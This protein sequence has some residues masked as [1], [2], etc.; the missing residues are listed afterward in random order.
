VLTP[1]AVPELEIDPTTPV[2]FSIGPSKDLYQELNEQIIEFTQDTDRLVLPNLTRPRLFDI[3]QVKPHPASLIA[4]ALRHENYYYGALWISYDQP[5]TFSEDEVRF[6]TT[7]GGQAAI[8]AANS[9]LYQNA[10][11]GRRRLEAILSSSPDPMLVTDR[12]NRL[13]LANPAA[14]QVLNLGMDTDEGQPIEEVI[15]HSKIIELMTSSNENQTAE[16]AFEDGF[17]YSATA[18]SVLSEGQRVGRVCILQDVTHFKELDTLKSE[19][20]STVSHDLRT[21]LTLMRGYAT[22]LEMVGKLNEQ[23][24]TYVNKIVEGVGSMSHLVNNLLDLGRIE[25]GIGLKLELISPKD[26]VDRV[27]ESLRLQIIQKRIK[28]ETEFALDSIQMIEADQALLQQALHNLLDNAIKFTRP[29]G[30]IIVRLKPTRD[31]MIFEVEDN[32]IGISPM[33]QNFLFEKFHRITLQGTEERKGT[34]LG[35]AIVKSI[36]ERHNGRVWVDSKLGQG[37]KFYME[38]PVNQEK[39]EEE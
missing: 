1:K 17:V 13:L 19:F 31:M 12:R 39:H 38:I 32:G 25:A 26:V 35:L 23:Q 2:T 5:H 29:E 6:T 4:V 34:G 21:P 28:L 24:N 33:D 16:I 36:V 9:R 11:L 10:E 3:N 14:W 15:S 18:T 7:L 8:A 20:V 22:M 27:V 37:S 30:K